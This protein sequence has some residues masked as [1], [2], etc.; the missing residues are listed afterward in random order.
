M[1]YI[2]KFNFYNFI[3]KKQFTNTILKFY[4]IYFIYTIYYTIEYTLLYNRVVHFLRVI[5]HT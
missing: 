2:L 5:K 1:I 3:N 4:F